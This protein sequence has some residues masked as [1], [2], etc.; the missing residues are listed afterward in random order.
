MPNCYSNRPEKKENTL[1][2]AE[3]KNQ[4]DGDLIREEI[5]ILLHKN[6]LILILHLERIIDQC[7]G[8]LGVDLFSLLFYEGEEL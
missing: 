7:I 5:C 2:N 3:K 6:N 1:H 8:F 4:A